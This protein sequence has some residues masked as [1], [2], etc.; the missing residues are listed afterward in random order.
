MLLKQFMGEKFGRD[1]IWEGHLATELWTT[2]TEVRAVLD[3]QQ[4]PLSRVLNL[5]VG[6]TLMLNATPNSEI[7]IRSGTIPLTTGR[8][9]R[10]GQ[11]IA[12]RVEAPVRAE[13]AERLTKHRDLS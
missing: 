3:E 8:M 4:V 5:K 1:N 10:K 12:V 6:D 13:I 2:G 11:N 7:S 9:G